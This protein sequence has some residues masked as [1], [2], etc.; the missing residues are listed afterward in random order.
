MTSEEFGFV[1]SKG[2]L[3]PPKK[4]RKLLSL[5]PKTQVKYR[6]SPKGYLI[7]EIIHSLDQLLKKPPIAKVTIEE[8][9]SLSKK[10][11]KSGVKDGN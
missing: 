5:E 4:L 7:V 8:T 3:Y 1:G 11:Q 6:S 9:E 2:E 10:M